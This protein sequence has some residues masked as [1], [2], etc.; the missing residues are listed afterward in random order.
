MILGSTR[1]VEVEDPEA[2][3]PGAAAREAVITEALARTVVVAKIRE[4]A[5]DQE[6][7]GI[8]GSKKLFRLSPSFLAC[9][10][11]LHRFALLRSE[12]IDALVQ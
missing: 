4:A 8:P 2:E 5:K 7:T 12:Y 9:H 6:N 10:Y 11:K 1:D 3:G